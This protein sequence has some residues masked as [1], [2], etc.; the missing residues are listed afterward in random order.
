MDWLRSL[1][2]CVIVSTGVAACGTTSDDTP[3][4]A[5]AAA[6]ASAIT[7]FAGYWVGA[8]EAGQ[9]VERSA[10][11]LIEEGLDQQFTVTWRNLEA[12]EGAA[13]L[14]ERDSTLV[15]LPGDESGTW[16]S[17]NSGEVA[18]G[19]I[20]AWAVV[21]P[22]DTLVVNIETMTADGAVERQTYTR[23]VAGDEMQ[24]DY[25]RRVNNVETRTLRGTYIRASDG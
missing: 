11:V 17:T 21:D 6:T 10:S 22:A 1:L 4:T 18:D 23:Q 16:Q 24:L 2:I 13:A 5:S 19:D 14:A 9:E 3:E 12:P 15:F 8:T 25:V 20:R 7:P